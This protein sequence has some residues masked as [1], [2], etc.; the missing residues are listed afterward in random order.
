MTQLEEDLMTIVDVCDAMARRADWMKNPSLE[1]G[2][3]W[4]AHDIAHVLAGG[5]LTRGSWTALRSALEQPD[6]FGYFGPAW[7]DVRLRMAD[8][9]ARAEEM[10]R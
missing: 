3:I 8:V 9:L 5:D 10:T 6:P 1:H 2:A 7:P 4:D